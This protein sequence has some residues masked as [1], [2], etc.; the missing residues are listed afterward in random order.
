M[1][2]SAEYEFL[3]GSEKKE[4]EK[5]GGVTLSARRDDVEEVT[6]ANGPSLIVNLSSADFA[7]EG[8]HIPAGGHLI[9][10]G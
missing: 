10:E 8:T 4:A 7:T 6:H 9:R 5:G 2:W 1:L 3:A